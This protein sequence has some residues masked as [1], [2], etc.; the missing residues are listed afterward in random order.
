MSKMNG[1]EFM[2][3]LKNKK[4]LFNLYRKK[5]ASQLVKIYWLLGLFE[6]SEPR[7]EKEPGKVISLEEEFKSLREHRHLPRWY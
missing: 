6:L 2:E 1:H 3:F 5:R 4:E 7:I